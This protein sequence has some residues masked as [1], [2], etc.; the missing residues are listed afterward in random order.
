M[1][2]QRGDREAVA[3]I[4]NGGLRQRGQRQ[5]AETFRQRDPA[6]YRTRHGHRVPAYFRHSGFTGKQ[7]RMPARRRT[8]G[9]VQTVQLF[10]VPDD[11]K[12]VAADPVAGRLNHRQ[13]H[14][15]GNGRIDGIPAQLQHLHACLSRQRLRCRN[16]VMAQHRRAS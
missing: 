5:R 10:T 3:R 1:A 7:I 13:R 2:N 16:R 14:R 9:R 8:T 15:G 6:G 11:G 12:G 4:V